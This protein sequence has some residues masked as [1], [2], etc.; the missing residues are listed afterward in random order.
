MRDYGLRAIWNGRAIERE[1]DP[2]DMGYGLIKIA[3]QV[4]K[5]AVGSEGLGGGEEKRQDTGPD[6]FGRKWLADVSSCAGCN[7]A[8]HQGFG[9]FGGDHDHWNAGREALQAALLEELKPV[10]GRHVDV[11][12]DE[13]EFALV[14]A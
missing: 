11:R 3:R 7:G 9:A 2:E 13:V 10:H 8:K 5:H 12:E 6:L 4:V 1:H 14:L